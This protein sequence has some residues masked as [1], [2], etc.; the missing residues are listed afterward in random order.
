MASF[1]LKPS[2]VREVDVII[3]GKIDAAIWL[4]AL[5]ATLTKLANFPHMGR[6]RDDLMLG[7]YVFPFRSHN[8]F[9]DLEDDGIVILHVRTP[10]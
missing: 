8:I 6:V 9:Y 3:Q 4:D 7:T 5:E 1:R 2:A 10:R